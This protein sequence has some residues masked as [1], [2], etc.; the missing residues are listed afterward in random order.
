MYVVRNCGA[1]YAGYVVGRGTGFP[2]LFQRKA[3]RLVLLPQMAYFITSHIGDAMVSTGCR[4]HANAFRAWRK[5]VNLTP[6]S[7]TANYDYALA[8]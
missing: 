1:R 8:A 5:H 3:F 2:S 6:S 7:L 4:G